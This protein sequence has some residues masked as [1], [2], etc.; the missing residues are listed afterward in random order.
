[1]RILGLTRR[2]SVTKGK[3][4]GASIWFCMQE[5]KALSKASAS[6]VSSSITTR[7]SL[8]SLSDKSTADVVECADV[9][10]ATGSFCS[11]YSI[12]PHM[13]RG[14]W[15]SGNGCAMCNYDEEQNIWQYLSG[16]INRVVLLSESRIYP[17]SPK[18]CRALFPCSLVLFFFGFFLFLY[19]ILLEFPIEGFSFMLA[20]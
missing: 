8:L 12:P 20:I 19:E 17:G 15:S 16:L 11:S 14:L 6:Y 10:Y 9:D 3:N 4:S 5:G 18:I 7:V 1:M 2:K 13:A